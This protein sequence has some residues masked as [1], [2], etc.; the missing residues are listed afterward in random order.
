MINSVFYIEIILA[1]IVGVLALR[2][3]FTWSMAQ[4]LKLKEEVYKAEQEYH[5]ALDELNKDPKNINKREFCMLKG[6]LFYKYKIPDYFHYPLTDASTHIEF[7]DNREHRL[8]LVERDIEES[9]K[10]NMSFGQTKAA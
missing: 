8:A 5:E 3:Y 1:V 9:K 7:M 6:E 10:N 2:S 4:D